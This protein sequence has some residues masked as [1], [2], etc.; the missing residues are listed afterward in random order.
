VLGSA[1][2]SFSGVRATD[3]LGLG[4]LWLRDFTQRS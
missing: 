2:A 3:K 1:L 4:S